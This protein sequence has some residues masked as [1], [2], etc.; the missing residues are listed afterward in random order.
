MIFF[1]LYLL[2]AA[3]CLALFYAFYM[4]LLRNCTFFI[5]NR[6]FLMAGLLL[7]FIIPLLKFSIFNR[8]S[9]A[10]F[11]GFINL[12]LFD[13]EYDFLQTQNTPSHV[14]TVN[15][16]LILPVVY[17][18]GASVLLFRF[19]ISIIRINRMAKGNAFG[20]RGKARIV[21]VDSKVP[22]SFFHTI[23][24]PDSENNQLIIEHE[25]A[26]IEQ[27]H[28]FDLLLTEIAA[29][30][31]WF[32]PF[33]FLYKSSIKLV[34][35]FLAD[36]FVIRNCGQ[37]ENYLGCMLRRV[38]IVNAGGPLSYFYC[39]TIKKRIIMITKNKTSLKYLG[40]Y[41]LGLPLVC[42]LLFAFTGDHHKSVLFT[43]NVKIVQTCDNRPSIY[44]LDSKKVTKTSGYGERINPITKE[45]D[46]HY[47]IDFA[48]PEGEEILSTANGVVAETDFDA[49]KG[50]YVLIKHSDTYST[51]YSHLQHVSVKTGDR[52]EKGQV[53]GYAGNTGVSTGSH[54]HYEVYK[55][56][57]R[58]NP[59]DYLPK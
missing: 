37:V 52:T 42:L 33:V 54:L 14:S 12:S 38:Q 5:L 11:S 16:S 4:L 17:M 41:L 44:P 45:R 58:V 28:W 13:P 21:K 22:F 18:A 46:F 8:N 29:I 9:G 6:L 7:S 48:V 40:V 1:L 56:G 26:H 24:F 34:H 39:K 36:H 51:F 55:N 31:L 23:F 25:M 59:E 19:L 35:E 10:G 30:L 2:K 20:Y 27:F 57:E 3:V 49:K 47:G 15:F 43:N 32:N 53:I 50:N